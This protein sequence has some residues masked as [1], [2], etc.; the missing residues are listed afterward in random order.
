VDHEEGVLLASDLLD[1][2]QG[3]AAAGVGRM[4]GK[5]RDDERRGTA[6]LV[7]ESPGDFHLSGQ[8]SSR[9]RT[10]VEESLAG[11]QPE[12]GGDGGAGH[13]ALMEIG[14]AAGRGAGEYHLRDGQDRSGV[15]RLPVDEFRLRGKDVVAKPGHE[16]QIVGHSTKTHHGKMGVGVDQTGQ[17]Q[18]ALGGQRLFRAVLTLRLRIPGG[19]VKDLS[20]VD[21]DERIF[22]DAVPGRHRQRRSSPDDEIHFTNGR[23]HRHT[24]RLLFTRP[25]IAETLRIASCSSNVR[26]RRFFMTIRPLMIAVSTS[27]P[28]AA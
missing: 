27:A 19:D 14:V 5:R 15:D 16:R 28:E 17:D 26:M 4:T 24:E 18:T 23:D 25:A 10:G 1:G 12:T 3:F 13:A 22:D 7:E 20:L 2:L 9:L 21:D 6:P 8:V 11:D